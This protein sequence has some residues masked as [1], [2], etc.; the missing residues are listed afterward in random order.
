MDWQ[1]M[2]LAGTGY[3]NTRYRYILLE[4]GALFKAPFSVLNIIF[5][6]LEDD[7]QLKVY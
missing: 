1:T 2:S 5:E 4:K 3:S 7:H 6:G